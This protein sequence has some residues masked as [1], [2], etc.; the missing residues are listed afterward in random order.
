MWVNGYADWEPAL[1]IATLNKF[2]NFSI[3]SFSIDGSPI[4]SMGG[5]RIQPNSSVW[6][7]D[8]DSIDLL[9]LPGGDLWHE[10]GNK[11]IT[12]LVKS[13]AD[14]KGNI[15][16]ICDATI[17]LARLGYLNRVWNTSNGPH[18]LSEKV[19]SYK[20]WQYYVDLPAVVH[21]NIITANGAGMVEFAVEIL[22]QQK[23]FDDAT[24]DKIYDLYK[25]GGVNNRLYQ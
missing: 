22:K 19:A 25:S 11:E 8:P 20:G 17:F 23:V 14:R 2:S 6:E 9:I 10:G 13:L 3:H 18:Y 4:Q 15:A 12:P 1:A 7:I 21:D 16:A 5:I 24:L